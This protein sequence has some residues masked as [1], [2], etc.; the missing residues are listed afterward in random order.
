MP[1]RTSPLLV[2]L[3]LLAADGPGEL[4]LA[5]ADDPLGPAHD[6]G[7][8]DRTRRPPRRQRG[9]G[10]VHRAH[11]VGGRGVGEAAEHIGGV[12][13]THVGPGAA[14]LGRAPDPADEVAEEAGRTGR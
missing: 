14:G 1:R 13:G 7:P 4:V 6:L 10:G 8:L 2:E 9:R 11:R 12:G 3:A 5:L